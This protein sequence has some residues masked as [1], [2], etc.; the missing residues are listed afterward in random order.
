[1]SLSARVYRIS[2]NS[3]LKFVFYQLKIC[4]NRILINETCINSGSSMNK[5]KSNS[6]GPVLGQ[7]YLDRHIVVLSHLYIPRASPV[8]SVSITD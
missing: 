4:K 6:F 1:M 8:I 3:R 5:R 2:T 7:H